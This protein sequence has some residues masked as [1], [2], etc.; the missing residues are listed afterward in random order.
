MNRY[1]L[2][3]LVMC[4]LAACSGETPAATPGQSGRQTTAAGPTRTRLP[5]ATP[6]RPPTATPTPSPAHA[7]RPSP[8]PPPAAPPTPRPRPA[9]IPLPASTSN[10]DTAG[11]TVWVRNLADVISRQPAVAADGRVYVTAGKTLYAFAA[12]GSESWRATLAPEA[13]AG[14]AAEVIAAPDGRVMVIAGNTL[15]TF[16]ADGA[17]GWHWSGE[18]A[19]TALPAFAADGTAYLMTNRS[20][21]WAFAP[22]G[23]VRWTTRPCAMSGSGPWP[24]AAV[25]LDN[26]VYAACLDASVYALDPTSGDILWAFTAP[27]AGE[28]RHS[29][30]TTPLVGSDG[31]IYAADELGTLFALR[32]DGQLRWSV[33]LARGLV[34]PA[35]LALAPDNAVYLAVANRL[36]LVTAEGTVRR[37]FDLDLQQLSGLFGQNSPVAV[38]ADGSL[39]A[40]TTNQ[41]LLRFAATGEVLWRVLL[42]EQTG[43]APSPPAVGR[44]HHRL[45]IGLGPQLRAIQMD[46]VLM[47]A[48]ALLLTAAAAPSEVRLPLMPAAALTPLNEQLA[49]YRAYQ[50]LQALHWSPDGALLAAAG[51]QG[52]RLFA[53]SG[54]SPPIALNQGIETA[55]LAF[56]PTAPYLAAAARD[57]TVR[58]WDLDSLARLASIRHDAPLADPT[59]LVFLRGERQELYLLLFAPPVDDQVGHLYLYDLSDIADPQLYA[60]YSFTTSS[61]TSAYATAADGRHVV[62]GDFLDGVQAYSLP[63]GPLG[64]R[65]FKPFGPPNALAVSDAGNYAAAGTLAGRVQV[66]HLDSGF[67]IADI[68]PPADVTYVNTQAIVF[69]QGWDEII[70]GESFRDVADAADQGRVAWW[71]LPDNVLLGAYYTETAITHLALHPAEQFLAVATETSLLV[72][73][74]EEWGANR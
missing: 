56:D 29:I 61:I 44:A 38:A 69:R 25:G 6:T 26:T 47:E 2:V 68:R 35:S 62:V 10:L 48:E 54:D 59:G 11:W 3:I 60:V 41:E 70:Y 45:Y 17:P 34:A 64:S 13:A 19:L 39:I 18:D 12:D 53:G 67:M 36:F 7:P 16:A 33:Q 24:G 27:D 65:I 49:A 71:S 5:T 46:D 57:G 42:A 52:V 4:C 28:T 55:A 37:T 43:V 32:P 21:L 30:V 74:L 22:D 23:S 72:T 8:T 51:A 73:D 15:Y 20:N 1:W 66:V 40:K 58:I 9:A 63:D 50:G 31:T 14:A